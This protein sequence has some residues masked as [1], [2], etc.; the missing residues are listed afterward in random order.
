MIV[1]LAERLNVGKVA[2]DKGGWWGRYSKLDE[3][4]EVRKPLSSARFETIKNLMQPV[5]EI[6]EPLWR[7]DGKP[8]RKHILLVIHSYSAQP[9]RLKEWLIFH[10]PRAKPLARRRIVR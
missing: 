8:T 5:M 2:R 7:I 4:E 3:G 6:G 9:V 1:P 10:A